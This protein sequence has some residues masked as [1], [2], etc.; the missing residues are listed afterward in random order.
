MR[1]ATANLPV[2]APLA[3][4]HRRHAGVHGRRRRGQAHGAGRY[5]RKG[6]GPRGAGE[7]LAHQ[8]SRG[9]DGEANGGRAAEESTARWP[10][11]MVRNGDGGGD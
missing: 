2:A 6:G 1:T 7:R 5:R 8:E 3:K 10:P 11:A 9:G 4:C